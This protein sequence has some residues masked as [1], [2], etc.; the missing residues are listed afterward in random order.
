MAIKRVISVAIFGA[1]VAAATA[2]SPSNDVGSSM[3]A[4]ELEQRLAT[5]LE[6]QT[7]KKPDKIDCPDDLKAKE[8]STA[9]CN[10]TTGGNQTGVTVTVTEL[11]GSTV[12]FNAELDNN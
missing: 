2:C 10:L 9:R 8:G 11:D 12:R 5:L 3:D 4:D 6:E 1:T 7:G